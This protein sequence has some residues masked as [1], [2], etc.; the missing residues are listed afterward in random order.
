MKNLRRDFERFCYRHQ[1][2]G[3]PNLMLWLSIGAAI[4]MVLFHIDPSNVVYRALCFDLDQIRGGQVWRL[5]TYILIP[6][7]MDFFYLAVSLF[8]Y[9]ILGRELER[10]W[11]TFRFNLFYFSG[12][13]IMDVAALI[14]GVDADVSYLNLSL[15]LAYAT[16]Y[17]N[18]QIWVSFLFPVKMKFLA[19]L[20]FGYTAFQLIT[21]P[22]PY[23]IFPLF[24]ILNYFLFFGADI[25][26]VLPG[27][28]RT[29]RPKG[30]S[31]YGGAA[32]KRQKPNPNW[33]KQYTQKKPQAPDYRHKCTVCGRTDVSNPELE[34]RYCSKCSG[35]H[36]YCM[37]HINDHPHI[38]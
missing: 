26:D 38:P 30:Y 22:F 21:Y 18:Q 20:Y 33:A 29:R 12:V 14:L 19:W 6:T 11:G 24:A 31:P 25:V 7:S 4:I 13:L 23:N 9:Y 8:L 3:I 36:C 2:I 16:K 17:P 35:Y 5:L 10:S 28:I 34:F 27:M 37:D 1:N 15:F 32:Q